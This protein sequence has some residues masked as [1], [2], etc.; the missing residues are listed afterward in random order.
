MNKNLLNE[1]FKKHLGLLHQKLNLNESFNAITFKP[2]EIVKL[3]NAGF[4]K[5]SDNSFY[6]KGGYTNGVSISTTQIPNTFY[7]GWSSEYDDG[8]SVEVQG[9]ENA[10]EKALEQL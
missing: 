5:E 10:I 4:E 3:T 7:V 6:Q 2:D 8:D 9:I 1:T